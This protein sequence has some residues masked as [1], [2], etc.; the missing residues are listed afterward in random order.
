LH[1]IFVRTFIRYGFAGQVVAIIEE[2][3]H[4]TQESRNAVEHR[5]T[6]SGPVDG[7][8]VVA[9]SLARRHQRHGL[10]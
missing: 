10:A 7:T 5:V 1:Y 8:A 3:T 9:R 4:T 6:L 2:C